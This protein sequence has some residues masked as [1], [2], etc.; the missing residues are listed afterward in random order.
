MYH[1]GASGVLV[2]NGGGLNILGGNW[3]AGAQEAADAISQLEQR[4]GRGGKFVGPAGEALDLGQTR[5]AIFDRITGKMY[6]DV[7]NAG[8]HLGVLQ[9]HGL[10][11]ETGRYVGG[12]LEAAGDGRLLFNP[13][14]GTFPFTEYGLPSN[15][16]DIVRGTGVS[17]TGLL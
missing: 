12:F 17:I 11:T 8:S 15:I 13:T 4:L 7:S 16:L 1:V 5:V 2:H 6:Y 9:R 14:S 3:W 10:P